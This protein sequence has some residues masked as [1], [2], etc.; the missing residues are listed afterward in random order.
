MCSPYCLKFGTDN[1]SEDEIKGKRVLEVGAY[2]VNGTLRGHCLSHEPKEYI[3]VDLS[4]GNCVDRVMN[5][6]DLVREFGKNSFDVVITTE[7]LEHVVEWKP[8][9]ANMKQVVKPGGIIVITTRSQGFPFH[10]Y[11]VDAWRFE[12]SDMESI[13]SDFDIITV[14]PDPFEPGVFIKARKPKKNWVEKNL[15][16]VKLYSIPAADYV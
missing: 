7:M 9:I 1:L 16:P 12:V 14:V 15:G 8:V 5:A 11:P 3:G 10:E 13:F 4:E 6:E 2:N